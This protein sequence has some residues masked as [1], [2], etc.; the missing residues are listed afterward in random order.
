[1]ALL[2]AW[3]FS[4]VIVL[5]PIYDQ[6]MYWHLANGREM[7]NTGRIVNEEIFSYTHF[8]EKFDNHEWLGQIILY[9]IWHSF[10]FY[11]LLGFKLLITSLVVLLLYRTIRIISGQP[12]LAAVLC[13]FAVLA[14]FWRYCERPELFSLFNTALF[15]FILYGFHANQ[16]PR[17]LLWLIPLILVV[18][19]W[20]HGSV[21][22]LILFTLFVLGENAKHFL[23]VL[24]HQQSL[25]LDNLKYLNRCFAVAVLAVLINPF[26]LRSYGIIVNLVMG[27]GAG[28]AAANIM[29]MRPIYWRDFQPYILLFAWAML[30]CLRNI[31]RLDITQLLILLVFGCAAVRYSRVVGVA[32]IVLAT[33]I[34][35]LITYSTKNAKNRLEAKLHTATVIMA[36]VFIVGHGYLV[37]FREISAKSF[38]Y[39]VNEEYLPVGS[40]RFVKAM[41]L[42]GNLYNTG[43]FGGYL[44]YLITPERKI[45]QYNQHQV[46]GDT[47]RFSRHPEELDKWDINYAISDT[48]NKESTLLFPAQ[49]WARVYRDPN[50][51][52]V[53]RRVPQ[54]QQLI[55]MFETHYFD[56]NRSD[57]DL[58]S[59]ELNLEILPRL[60]FEMGVY[61]AYRKDGRIAGHW[62]EILTAWPGLRSQ[63][64]IQQLFQQALKYN[65]TGKL[66]HL[67]G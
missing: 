9:L 7:V 46:F 53:V 22:G 24:R 62:A 44:S 40:V 28:E 29:E 41:K 11:G 19:D 52:L 51:V 38:G 56:P 37:K 36:A 25:S 55:S 66:A 67:N 59:M 13:V 50:A 6:D 32:S 34:A 47:Y 1:M 4:I 8:G 49:N 12:G 27:Q 21:Y 2:G 61:L 31:R 23:P 10:G 18:W 54:N 35:S 17:R 48:H 43:H 64:N 63:P 16:L 39:H 30:L 57:K 60:T 20:L 65:N 33:I 15:S 42:T 45:F 26:G 14:G 58:H 5:Y 3:L